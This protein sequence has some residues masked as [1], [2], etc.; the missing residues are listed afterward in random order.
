MTL[1]SSG[2]NNHRQWRQRSRGAGGFHSIRYGYAQAMF[3]QAGRGF[4]GFR[5]IIEEDLTAG[6]RTTTTF[7]Q[8][9]PL[10]GQVADVVVNAMTR[11][12]TAAL[13]GEDQSVLLSDSAGSDDGMDGL[14][15]SSITYRIA[16][17]KYA[18]R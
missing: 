17:G 8:K 2:R 11:S 3:N 1:R 13:E 16:T 15:M 7:N 12:G 4:Q 6:L 9:F 5:T 18:G 14:R 10:A